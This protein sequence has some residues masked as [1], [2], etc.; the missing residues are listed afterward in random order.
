MAYRD[1]TVGQVLTSQQVDEFLMRQ[2]VMVFADSAARTTALSGV[3]VQGMLTYLE[4]TSTYETWTGAAWANISNPG[5]ITAVTAGTG[6]TGGGTTGDVTLNVDTAQF[7]T[8]DTV[9]TAQDLIVADGASSV[10]R[11][12]VGT[13]DQVLSVVAG[14]V[15]W[16]DAGG[17]GAGNY[18]NITAAGDHTVSLGSGLYEV[19]SNGPVQVDGVAFNGAGLANYASTITSILAASK[20]E[21]WTEVTS[22]TTDYILGLTFGNGVYVLGTTNGVI[23]T[24]TNGTTW[25]SRT[26]S[27]TDIQAVAFGDGLYL[28]AGDDGGL[29]TSTDATT[30][31]SRTSGF[32]TD[33]IQALTYGDG[34]YLAA[35]SQGNLSTSTDGTTWTSRTSGFGTDTINALTYGDNLY[36]A[37]GSQGKLFTSTDGTTWTSRTSGFGT[38]TINALT[39]GNGLY[40]AGGGGVKVT[41]SVNGI[42][43]TARNA[44]FTSEIKSLTYGCAL[45]MAVGNDGGLS[46]S[47]EGINWTSRATG[48]IDDMSGST[49]GAGLYLAAGRDGEMIISDFDSVLLSLELKTPVTTLS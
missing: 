20:G 37:A 40:L 36:I 17:G 41:T 42:N 7:I 39:Y 48:G 13:D 34:L 45:Y 22:G 23:R 18:Y 4:D 14:E 27:L 12:G 24:S 16:A 43:W 21:T 19:T 26:S 2:T 28:A 46:T 8:S 30:W 49:Y 6:L 10:T 25:T 31:T 9:T 38:D 44:A 47:P 33:N 32:G 11:L 5:D 35:G 15:A 29:L 3:L 1:F